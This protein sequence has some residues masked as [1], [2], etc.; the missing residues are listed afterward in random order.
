MATT[1][2]H[3]PVS[4]VLKGDPTSSK[5][6]VVTKPKALPKELPVGPRP[7]PPDYS[8]LLRESNDRGSSEALELCFH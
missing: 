5:H 4:L 6:W 2:P 1:S 8:R 3:W 7:A